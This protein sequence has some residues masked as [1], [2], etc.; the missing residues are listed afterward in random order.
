[1][2]NFAFLLNWPMTTKTTLTGTSKSTGYSGLR[3]RWDGNEFR[4]GP[5]HDANRD[6][7]AWQKCSAAPRHPRGRLPTPSQ[8]F[9]APKA[10]Q[11]MASSANPNTSA[12]TPTADEL[13]AFASDPIFSPEEEAVRC[14]FSLLLFTTTTFTDAC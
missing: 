12:A 3:P 11:T 10:L 8:P 6:F 4:I 1:M 14:T 13:A 5:W 9:V 2:K 7:T